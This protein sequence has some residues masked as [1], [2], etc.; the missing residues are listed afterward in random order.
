MKVIHDIKN[1]TIAVLQTVNDPEAELNKVKSIV[2]EEL[3]DLAD[4]LDNLRAEFKSSNLMDISKEELRE[5][6]TSDFLKSLKITHVRLAKNGGNQ[7]KIKTND[8]VPVKLNI[9][10]INTKRIIN[11]VISNALKHTT[12]GKVTVSISLE[13]NIIVL[14]NE[15]FIHVGADFVPNE[16]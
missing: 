12:N 6:L 14:K 16:N 3:E 10:R 13:S 11:N 15:G 9:Q 4:M 2:N 8:S 7:L 5:V 1:P